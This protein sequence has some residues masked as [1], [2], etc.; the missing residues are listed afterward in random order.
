MKSLSL[1]VLAAAVT[2]ACCAAAHAQAVLGVQFRD[3]TGT[4]AA[5]ENIEVWL[6]LTNSGDQDLVVDTSKSP[7]E[8][9]TGLAYPTQGRDRDGNLMDFATYSSVGAFISRSCTDTFSANCAATG[10]PYGWEVPGPFPAAQWFNSSNNFTLAAGDSVD[11]LT[12]TLVPVGGLAPLGT[13][14][15]TGAGL[16]FK[17]NGFAADGTT[18]LE[19]DIFSPFTCTSG[20]LNCGF[21]RT[22]VSAVPEPGAAALMALGLAGLAGLSIRRR[23]VATAA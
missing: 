9:V 6:K 17:L 18:L 5:N 15:I 4:V 3:P 8:V 19:A 1:R 16:G 22:V 13:Y 7:L 20:E 11:V 21:S 12:Y 2:L 23:R 10:A 14:T